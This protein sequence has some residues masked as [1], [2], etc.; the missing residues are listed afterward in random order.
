V[1]GTKIANIDVVGLAGSKDTAYTITLT[2][3]TTGPTLPIFMAATKDKVTI[4]AIEIN[5]VSIGSPVSVP[6]AM[7]APA[8]APIQ[9]MPPTVCPLPKVRLF[10]VYKQCSFN[11]F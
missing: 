6:F 1:A 7:P 11:R 3:N 2:V 4:S 8:I 10:C 9:A 5:A